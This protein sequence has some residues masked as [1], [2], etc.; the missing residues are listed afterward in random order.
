[1]QIF[2]IIYTIF[3]VKIG[4]IFAAIVYITLALNIVCFIFYKTWKVFQKDVYERFV[5]ENLN[6]SNDE[7]Q[8]V[9]K[10]W[11][12]DELIKLLRETWL[13][14]FSFAPYVHFKE[15]EYVGQYINVSKKGYRL[16]KEQ[17]PWPPVDG[18]KAVYCFGGSTTFGVGV[19]DNETYPSYLQEYLN[20]SS[21]HSWSVYNFGCPAYFSTQERILF[22]QLLL[23]EFK[24]DWAVFLDG[25]NEFQNYDGNPFDVR[26]VCDYFNG[27]QSTWRKL[28]EF[29]FV[30]RRSLTTFL[31]FIRM[32]S[33]PFYVKNNIGEEFVKDQG[34]LQHE[35]EETV[36]RYLNNVSLISSICEGGLKKIKPLFAVQPHPFYSYPLESRIIQR[37][38]NVDVKEL[39]VR[40]KDGYGLLKEKTVNLHG[41]PC[42]LWLADIFK[43][44]KSYKYVDRF[45]YSAEA[46]REIGNSIGM[47][48]LEDCT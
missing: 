22:A 7:L 39:R 42:F 30:R 25:V 1:M 18:G 4:I 29:K 47:R 5:E 11:Q 6:A 23:D 14:G 17:R 44:S 41:R 45:H 15:R 27:E 12:K 38:A 28:T 3:I 35:L 8:E 26:G 36:N 31:E 43:K 48:I 46:N 19:T 33:K 9:Y 40:L 24:P 20:S 2:E 10:G 32:K 13:R 16:N 34:S 37:I 21:L